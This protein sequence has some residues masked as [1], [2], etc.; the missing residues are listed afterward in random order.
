M[1][2]LSRLDKINN[3]FRSNVNDL[4]K[5]LLQQIENYLE[6]QALILDYIKKAEAQAIIALS[7]DFLNYNSHIIHYYLCAL[8]DILEII[9]GMFEGLQDD[10]T[11]IK[12]IF[13]KIFK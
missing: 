7:D 1:S 3:E 9:L 13:Y 10:F 5:T 12:N 2:N 6:Q 8:S 4:N 11:E